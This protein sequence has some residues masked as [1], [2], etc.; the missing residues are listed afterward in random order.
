MRRLNYEVQE[1]AAEEEDWFGSRE[2]HGNPR[3]TQATKPTHPPPL[4]P[5]RQRSGDMKGKSPQKDGGK[6]SGAISFNFSQ[7]SSKGKKLDL[8]D[9]ISDVHLGQKP[10]SHDDRNRKERRRERRDRTQ[11]EGSK[12]NTTSNGKNGDSGSGSGSGRK[13]YGGYGR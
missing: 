9:R 12:T 10:K 6:P 3:S 13:Y 4:G 11:S 5:K 2:R 7:S 8:A 1:L